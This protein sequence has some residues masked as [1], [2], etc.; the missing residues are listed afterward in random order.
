MYSWATSYSAFG[1]FS[2]TCGQWAYNWNN[3]ESFAK[4]SGSIDSHDLGFFV[5]CISIGSFWGTISSWLSF[6]WISSW[7]NWIVKKRSCLW[8]WVL[9]SSQSW[10]IVVGFSKYW[11]GQS[12]GHDYDSRSG[13]FVIDHPCCT[14][15]LVIKRSST[16][17]RLH[18]TRSDELES[19]W[20]EIHV[21]ISPSH[22]WIPKVDIHL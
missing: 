8:I 15:Y 19:M 13:L 17:F 14:H 5:D 6:H 3:A 16:T 18:C 1:E 12:R 11:K 7:L 10:V 9:S 22:Y 20:S 21:S 4:C 2:S